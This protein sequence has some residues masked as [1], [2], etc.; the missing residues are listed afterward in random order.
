MTRTVC[1][2]ISGC[3]HGTG[4]HFFSKDTLA[5]HC[6]GCCIG[7]CTVSHPFP[8]ISGSIAAGYIQPRFPI[9]G[10]WFVWAGA[11]NRW[12][13]VIVYDLMMFPN[14]WGQ[15]KESVI[16]E[17]VIMV[18][19]FAVTTLL[20]RWCSVELVADGLKRMRALRST[21]PPTEPHPVSLSIWILAAV[22]NLLL[23]WST[24]GWV[25]A[26][27]RSQSPGNFYPTLAMSLVLDLTIVAFDIS[28]IWKVAKTRRLRRIRN[29]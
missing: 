12:P 17:S 8:S 22:L 19:P 24:S 15:T 14:P 10:K 5:G 9:T 20:L 26:P 7:T 3:S 16:Q 29:R 28:L 25:L 13:L 6:R 4:R 11:A 27:S 2:V 1:R 18:V 23:G 21:T